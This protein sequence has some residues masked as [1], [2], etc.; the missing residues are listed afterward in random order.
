MK[1][2]FCTLFN[3]FYLSRGLLMYQSLANQCADFHL[4][5][6]AFDDVCY[7]FFKKENYPNL[8]VISLK[9]FED[10]ELLKVKPSRT[11]GEYCWT[12][13]SSTIL[14]S[15]EKYKLDNCTYIDA[16][17]YFYSDPKVL[18]EEMGDKSVLI[19]EHRFTEEYAGSAIYGKYCVQF[20]TFINNAKGM[21]VLRWWRNA[22][23]DWCYGRI[24]DGKFGDQK[25][26]DDWTT[27]FDCV[28][29]LQHL[30][31]GIAPWNIQQ[32]EF[33]KSDN[34]NITGKE[35]KSGKIFEAVFFHCHGL[36]FYTNKVV[37]LTGKDYEMTNNARELIYFDYVKK[38]VALKNLLNSKI[39]NVNVDGATE[40]SPKQPF[41]FKS[42]FI[43]YLRDTKHSF[44]NILG[45]SMRLK[46]KHAHYFFYNKLN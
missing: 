45:K 31:G 42:C 36:K 9:E 14:Y 46:L 19:T 40:V 43:E 26:L 7:D 18:V 29:E 44:S 8:T 33:K 13:A 20:V 41:T 23:I 22:C 38:I 12:C 28:H 1:L 2:N 30:G 37:S 3:S 24:E 25:Y 27:R 21:E 35:I 4:Y 39:P 16:D 10:A 6:F 17:M 15:I 11:A 34:G 5:V 32:Y